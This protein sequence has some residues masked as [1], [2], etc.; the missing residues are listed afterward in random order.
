MEFT[1]NLG[2]GEIVNLLNQLPANQIAKIKNEFPEHFI[3]EKAKIDISD[4]Q[5]FILAGPLMSDDQYA[6]FI[7]QRKHFN[8]WR[9]D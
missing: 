5:K 6:G 7:R 3:A 8:A 9:I 4:F 1:I 2:F